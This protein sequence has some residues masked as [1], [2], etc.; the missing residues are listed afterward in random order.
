MVTR[1]ETEL[2]PGFV[3][4]FLFVFLRIAH[5]KDRGSACVS[6]WDSQRSDLGGKCVNVNIRLSLFFFFSPPK[7][8]IGE[9]FDSQ[10]DGGLRAAKVGP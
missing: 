2:H 8:T 3:Y 6:N 9:P 7:L 1:A 4:L 5:F 10:T